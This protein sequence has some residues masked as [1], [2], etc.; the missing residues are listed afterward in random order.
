MKNFEE[1]SSYSH[2][3]TPTPTKEKSSLL[4]MEDNKIVPIGSAMLEYARTGV[5]PKEEK[6]KYFSRTNLN[7]NNKS[8]DSIL[9]QNVSNHKSLLDKNQKKHF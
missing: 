5:S 1:R 2:Y 8:K 9:S 3:Q 4:R 7:N 6:P